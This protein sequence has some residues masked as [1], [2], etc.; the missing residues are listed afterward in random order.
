MIGFLPTEVFNLVLQ[1]S[2]VFVLYI[3]IYIASSIHVRLPAMAINDEEKTSNGQYD[4]NEKSSDEEGAKVH[5]H[6]DDFQGK[7]DPFGDESNSEVKY[8]TMEWW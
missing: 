5:R 3:P 7:D 4:K 2:L 6:S 1:Y 8:R